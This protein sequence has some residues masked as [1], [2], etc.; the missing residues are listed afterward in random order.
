MLHRKVK[1]KR[2][3]KVKHI[4]LKSL[5][6]K[7]WKLFSEYIRRSEKGICYICG[8]R[9]NWK[10][11]NAAHYIHRDSLDYDTVNIHCS[12]VRCNKWLSG[13][14]GIYAERLI[15]EYGEEAIAEL[16]HR[17]NQVKKFTITELQGLI[18]KYSQALKEIKEER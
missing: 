8:N 10:E 15:A 3:K 5:R 4:S 11:Q 1:H 16:R 9:R 7:A 2:V 17:A 14:L 12:C 18:T 6:K 13:N